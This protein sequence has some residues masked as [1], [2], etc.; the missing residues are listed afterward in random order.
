MNSVKLGKALARAIFEFGSDPGRPCTR[1][2]F[3]GGSYAEKS[4][5]PMGGLCEVALA[6]FLVREIEKLES[7]TPQ[8]D[9]GMQEGG[10]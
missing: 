10:E 8:Q 2:Q 6:S 4:E 3:L 7:T 9:A 5:F 1:I